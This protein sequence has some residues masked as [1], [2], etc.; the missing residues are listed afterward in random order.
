MFRKPVAG[1]AEPLGKLGEP[2]RLPEGRHGIP[3]PADRCLIEDTKTE[4]P[5]HSQFNKKRDEW[6]AFYRP[7]TYICI[8]MISF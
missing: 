8:I 3:I 7:A 6:F 1:I 2:D 4:F 5:G